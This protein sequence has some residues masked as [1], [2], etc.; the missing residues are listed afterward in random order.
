MKLTVRIKK[1]SVSENMTSIGRGQGTAF[2]VDRH[3]LVNDIERYSDVTVRSNC[4]A[5]PKLL[6]LRY[7]LTPRAWAPRERLK[8]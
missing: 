1:R 5:G 4:P 8:I 6:N 2:F 7:T 3:M